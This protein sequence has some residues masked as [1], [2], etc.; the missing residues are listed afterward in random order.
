MVLLRVELVLLVKE[1]LAKGLS[2]RAER[3]VGVGFGYVV[4]RYCRM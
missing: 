1:S 3:G 4:Q 2:R